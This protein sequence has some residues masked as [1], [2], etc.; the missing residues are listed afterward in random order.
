M[1]ITFMIAFVIAFAIGIYF[2]IMGMSG[3]ISKQI[4]KESKK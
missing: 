3:I 1:S 2:I 4:N